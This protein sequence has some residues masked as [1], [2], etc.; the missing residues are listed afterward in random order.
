MEWLPGGTCPLSLPFGLALLALAVIAPSTAIHNTRCHA[1]GCLSLLL[2]LL[3]APGHLAWYVCAC[4]SFDQSPTFLFPL[5]SFLAFQQPDIGRCGLGWQRNVAFLIRH[6]VSFCV[7]LNRFKLPALA[8]AE[9]QRT[10][11]QPRRQN[12]YRPQPSV[13]AIA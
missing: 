1:A 11:P 9:P 7:P 3:H 13:I 10:R 12:L 5:L 2:L 4:L 6:L 8:Y